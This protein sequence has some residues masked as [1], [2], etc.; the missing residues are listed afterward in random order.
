MTGREWDHNEHYYVWCAG[1]G[2]KTWRTRKAARHM[3]KRFHPGDRLNAYRCP[4]QYL[5][6]HYGHLQRHDRDHKHRE[7]T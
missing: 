3:A 4:H 2:K 1:C 7:S 5:G 6:W